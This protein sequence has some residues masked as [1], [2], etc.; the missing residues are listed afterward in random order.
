MAPGP[1]RARKDV[2]S[3]ALAE[4]RR[5]T[6]YSEELGIHLLRKT[7]REYFKWFLA[8]LLFGGRISETLAKRTYR[9]FAHERLLTPRKILDA[10]WDYLVNPVMRKGGYVRYDESKSTQ[11]LR[12]CETLLDRYSGSLIR[13]HRDA[14]DS[15]DLE[16]RLESFYGVGPITTNIFLRE[17]RPFWPKADPEPLPAVREGARRAGIDLRA[18]G[19]HTL[20]FTRIEAGFIRHRPR[21]RSRSPAAGASAPGCRASR[22]PGTTPRPSGRRAP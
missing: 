8:S 17:L 13:L 1:V 12:D 5:T 2:A 4:L 19:R 14:T 9:S 3:L 21:S 6:L 22:R 7:D 11:I 20:T 15:A 10:G 16:A 18:F